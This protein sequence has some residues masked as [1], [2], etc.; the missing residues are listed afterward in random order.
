MTDP[1]ETPDVSARERQHER[2]AACL[3]GERGDGLHHGC[4]CHQTANVELGYACTCPTAETMAADL[5]RLARLV[6]LVWP[7]GIVHGGHGCLLGGVMQ[8]A[9][10]DLRHPIAAYHTTG[11]KLPHLL[12]RADD[13]LRRHAIDPDNLRAAFTERTR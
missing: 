7:N 1:V 2:H 10:Q 12:Q 13:E 6:S 5:D 4:G 3:L 11:T 9:A 8:T